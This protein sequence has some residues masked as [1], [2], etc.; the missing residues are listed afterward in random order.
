MVVRNAHAPGRT[1]VTV[2]LRAE[3]GE[4]VSQAKA[5]LLAQPLTVETGAATANR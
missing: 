2:E 4:M 1:I 3:S 5:I